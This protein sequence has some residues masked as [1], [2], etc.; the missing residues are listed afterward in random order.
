MRA[1]LGGVNANIALDT[2]QQPLHQPGSNN[3]YILPLQ[4]ILKGFEKKYPPRV[5]KLAVHPDLTDWRCKWGHRKGSSPQKKAVGDLEMIAF[6]YILRVGGYTAPK[7]QVRPPR[8]QQ[9]LVN[10]VTFFKLIKTCGFLSPVPINL[11]K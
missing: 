9:F 11:S 3:K 5:K 1:A 7:R 8:T 6:Y 2:R 4:H 10:D